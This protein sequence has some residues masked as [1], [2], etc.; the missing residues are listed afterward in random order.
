MTGLEFAAS[1]V[2]SLAW[3]AVIG[4]LILVLRAQIRS[5]MQEVIKQ[6]A[7][8]IE[9]KAPGVSVKLEKQIEDVD[10]QVDVVADKLGD[11]DTWLPP[12]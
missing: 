9:V 3:P 2:S 12:R 6:I 1:L 11:V 5:A 4:V 10:K 8:V 7:R